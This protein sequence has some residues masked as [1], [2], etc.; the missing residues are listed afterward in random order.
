MSRRSDIHT[1]ADKE[2]AR[3]SFGYSDIFLYKFM[4]KYM[5]P[6]KRELS[7]IFGLMVLFS[8]V[9]VAG[10]ILLMLTINRFST[11]ETGSKFFGIKPIDSAMASTVDR[12]ELL[13]SN[14]ERIWLEASVIA[15]V[16][17]LLQ[18]GVY[19]ISRSQIMKIATIGLKAELSMRLGVKK[20]CLMANHIQ[21]E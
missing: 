11:G 9:T 16:Y 15:F 12:L 14:V 5:R 7:Y 17:L 1:D 3:G 18:I 20:N 4:W 21:G 13:V 19:F 8:M 6:Y 10:P 2:E